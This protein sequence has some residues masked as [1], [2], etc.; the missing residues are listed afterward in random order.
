MEKTVNKIASKLNPC[1]CFQTIGEAITM[2]LNL[3]I[4]QMYWTNV[5][6]KNI[7]VSHKYLKFGFSC[8]DVTDHLSH[9]LSCLILQGECYPE[10][11]CEF[12]VLL[13]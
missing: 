2:S 10:T 9:K 12:E 3:W 7:W 5:F 11:P 6:L 13:P 1:F 4:Y 8:L